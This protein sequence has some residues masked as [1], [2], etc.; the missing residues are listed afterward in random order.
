MGRQIVKRK[1]YT[2]LNPRIPALVQTIGSSHATAGRSTS[3]IHPRLRFDSSILSEEE[4]QF[5]EGRSLLTSFHEG[6]HL[7]SEDIVSELKHSLDIDVHRVRIRELYRRFNCNPNTG[8]SSAQVKH[9]LR[10]FGENVLR[11]PNKHSEWRIIIHHL[12]GGFS[13]L[14]LIGAVLCFS[15][16]WILWGNQELEQDCEEYLYVGIVLSVV[17]FISGVCTYYQEKQT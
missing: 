7:S 3:G 14:L 9:N 8:L 12:L 11:P 16:T 1:S 15:A 4:L 10:K 5:T 2:C 17:V 6:F 13:F